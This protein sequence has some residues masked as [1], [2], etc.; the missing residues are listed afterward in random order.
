[1]GVTR[2]GQAKKAERMLLVCEP[3]L[4]EGEAKQT[5]GDW[6]SNAVKYF[7]EALRKYQGYGS[8]S[9]APGVDD[10]TGEA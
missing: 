2:I 6:A 7:A 10:S 4:G 1:M 9:P 8:G 5:E 3:Q